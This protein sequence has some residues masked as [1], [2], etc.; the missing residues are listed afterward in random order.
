MAN[1]VYENFYL[2]NEVED[3]FTSHLDLA[4]FCTVDKGLEGTAGMK[5]VINVYSATNGTEKL[6][7]VRSPAPFNKLESRRIKASKPSSATADLMLS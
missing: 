5:R 1:Q 2:S 6:A 7:P 4:E 3:Q